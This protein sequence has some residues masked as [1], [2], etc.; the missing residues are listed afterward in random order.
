MRLVRHVMSA[1]A[2][3]RSVMRSLRV[4]QSVEPRRPSFTGCGDGGLSQIY[5][6]PK[7]SAR[8]PRTNNSRLENNAP[9]CIAISERGNTSGHREAILGPD[10]SFVAY[11]QITHRSGAINNAFLFMFTRSH[12]HV[13]MINSFLQTSRCKQMWFTVQQL[14]LLECKCS[15]L[16]THKSSNH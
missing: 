5:S 9:G 1:S 16:L 6:D 7:S 15:S 14:G 12:V 10:C 4:C 3:C 2:A 13:V 8:E 11:T